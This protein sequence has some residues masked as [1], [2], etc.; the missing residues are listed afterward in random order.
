MLTRTSSFSILTEDN[1]KLLKPKMDL[2]IFTNLIRS[3]KKT[4]H[5]TRT[6]INW[7]M[8]SGEIIAVYSKN[9]LKPI[10]KIS[11]QNA[12]FKTVKACCIHSYHCALEG[13]ILWLK[14]YIYIPLE[15]I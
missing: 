8:I 3:Y 4:Q 14:I 13:Q 15:K 12:E 7:L 1:V 5:I 9:H 10:N 6:V 11:G 2:T